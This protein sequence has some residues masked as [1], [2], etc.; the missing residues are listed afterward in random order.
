MGTGTAQVEIFYWRAVFG[1]TGNRAE[2]EQLVEGQLALKNI[3]FGKAKL[4]FKIPGRDHLAV[5]YDIFQIR[6][7]LAQGVDNRKPNDRSSTTVKMLCRWRKKEL[8]VFL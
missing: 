5:Q 2:K 7:V 1:P 8:T 3:S 6:R 4:L